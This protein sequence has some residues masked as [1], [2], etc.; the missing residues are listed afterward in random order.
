MAEMSSVFLSYARKDGRDLALKLQA[1]LINAGFDVWLDTSDIMG[2]DSWSTEIEQAIDDCNIVLA[3][4]ST[5]S[6]ASEICRA[7]HL[8]SLRKN[9]IVIPVRVHEGA[10]MPLYLEALNYR[11]FADPNK[12]ESSLEQVIKDLQMFGAEG[13]LVTAQKQRIREAMDIQ[14]KEISEAG[15]QRREAQ[16]RIVGQRLSDIIDHFQD[17]VQEQAVISELLSKPSTRVVSIIGRGGMGKTA[18]A[19]KI[20]ADIETNH[21]PHIEDDI[22]TPTPIDG[23]IY[24]STNTAG[25]SLERLFINSAQLLGGEQEKE[26][27]TTWVNPQLDT[28]TKITRLLE[29]LQ[30]GNYVILMDNMEDLLT[31]DG[32]IAD[33]DLVAFFDA[34]LVTP[35]N[36]SLLIT[37]RMPLKFSRQVMRFDNQVS[38]SEGLPV[39]HGITMLRELDASGMA[40]LGDASDEELAE[41]VKLVHGMPRALEILAGI[42]ANDPFATIDE[43]LA[44]FYQQEDVVNDLVRENY[45]RLETGER[46]VMEAL[47]VFGRPVQVV[48]IDFLLENIA[49]GL[50]VPAI[51][52]RLMQSH[53]VSVDK[54]TK[55]ASLHPIDKAFIYSQL[56]ESGDDSR[57]KLERR[58]AAYY[59]QL[60][61]P[62][63]DWHTLDDI[64]PQLFEFE[65]LVRAGDF[66]QAYELLNHLDANF[67]T[68][69]GHIQRLF[70]MRSQLQP[71]LQEALSKAGNL[72]GLGKAALVLSKFAECIEYCQSALVIATELQQLDLRLEALYT[73][74]LCSDY[75][76]NYRAAVDYFQQALALEDTPETQM[77]RANSLDALAAAYN[78]LNH[79]DDALKTHQ[80]ALEIRQAQGDKVAEGRSLNNMGYIYYDQGDF[81]QALAC[82][83]DA[84]VVAEE[85]RSEVDRMIRLS[86]IGIV[87]VFFGDYEQAEARVLEALSLSRKIGDRR[88]ECIRLGHIGSIRHDQGRYPEALEHFK[89]GLAIAQDIHASTWESWHLA[90]IGYANLMV[91]NVSEAKDDL[92]HSVQ[93][94]TE[95][96]HARQQL[97]SGMKLTMYYINQGQL[98]EALET[99][100][101][102]SQYEVLQQYHRCLAV[103]GYLALLLNQPDIAREKLNASVELSQDLLSRSPRFFAAQYSLSIARLCLAQLGEYPLQ[104]AIADIDAALALNRESGVV[105]ELQMLTSRLGGNETIDNLN[106]RLSDA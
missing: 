20:M 35:S 94:A 50:N 106:A 78:T 36:T 37:T 86:N 98:D 102:A 43:V 15:E 99:V 29:A 11:D 95:I 65:H 14:R 2:G 84:L 33:P 75:T 46:R 83:S 12:Y 104:D 85:T 105:A 69:E 32:A 53:L 47:A 77:Q 44:D 62:E 61:I 74:G 81:N 1:D 17:R 79:Y 56:P 22:E 34:A 25:I 38:L 4:I 97:E 3:L 73:M 7:E 18:L 48:A 54:R 71:E 49:P 103:Y 66:Q 23:I 100:K 76:G 70:E 64:Q 45:K 55:T 40:G 96:N 19:S 82:F 6:V 39:E 101:V 58:A 26:L 30:S 67:L 90:F 10:D 21:W 5:G 16:K 27:N 80:Q 92:M 88:R 87:H 9:R 8:R 89:A 28:Q 59:Q 41:A 24:M 91:G 13:A 52:R 57:A 31:E 60:A 68:R 63:A 51:A 93:I 42:L 72:V